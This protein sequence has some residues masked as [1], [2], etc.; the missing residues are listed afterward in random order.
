MKNLIINNKKMKQIKILSWNNNNIEE[1]INTFLSENKEKE[2]I[3]IR[4][5]EDNKSWKY[6]LYLYTCFIIY[7]I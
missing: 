1:R 4:L 7:I 5:F 3:D 2:I 6:N